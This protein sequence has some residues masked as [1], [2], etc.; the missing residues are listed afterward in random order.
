M[1]T[2]NY[3]LSESVVVT[4]MVLLVLIFLL[5][6]LS[7]VTRIPFY[8][9]E[10]MRLCVLGSIL[11]FNDKRNA[12]FLALSLPIVSFFCTGHPVAY[13]S[14]IMSLELLFNVWLLFWLKEKVKSNFMSFFSSILLSKIL[15]YIMKFVLIKM[16]LIST[17]LIDTNLYIQLIVAFALSIVFHFKTKKFPTK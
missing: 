9:F 11:L 7:H 4:D 1:N 15:Y 6:S 8:L 2:Y 12:Y 14:A 3:K 16:T 10:P 17:S 5:P 13:K